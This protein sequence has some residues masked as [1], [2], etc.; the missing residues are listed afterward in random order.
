[1]ILS[2]DAVVSSPFKSILK[3]DRTTEFIESDFFYFLIPKYFLK[4]QIPAFDLNLKG[5]SDFL[6]ICNNSLFVS[7]QIE[8][9]IIPKINLI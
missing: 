1:M 2:P 7:L 6:M 3:S 5:A 9:D 4:K 8:S